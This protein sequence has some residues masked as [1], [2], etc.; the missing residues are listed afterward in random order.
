MF[1]RA[2]VASLLLWIWAAAGH[3][4]GSDSHILQ[5]VAPGL[6][7]EHDRDGL[8][9]M[10]PVR[11]ATSTPWTDGVQEFTGV[12]L[13]KLLPGLDA[14]SRIQLTAINDYA[15]SMPADAVGDE[16]PVV[17]YERNG[18]PMSLR[19]KGPFWLIYP[20]DLAAEYQTETVYARSVWQLVKIE[21]M[22][23]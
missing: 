22:V 18:Q 14:Q 16:Y 21:V 15:V 1:P 17:A 10:N 6:V 3:A 7:A 8:R 5:I 9:G 13:S 2:I 11:I 4:Q 19:D 23:R 20:F 12:P